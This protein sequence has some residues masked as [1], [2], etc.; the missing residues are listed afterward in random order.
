M[1]ISAAH[2]YSQ[3]T[4]KLYEVFTDANFYQEKFSGVGAKNVQILDASDADE[5]FSITTQRDVPADV[6][7][8]LKKFLGEWNTIKQ[9]EVWQSYGDNEF[10]S[11]ISIEAA[12]VPVKIGGS[13]LLRP[14][15]D[16]CVN[17][18]E[19]EIEC[20]VPFVGKSLAEFVAADSK[21][22]LEQEY[23]FIVSYLRGE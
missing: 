10:G 6:P 14:E 19:L 23:Q 17:D 9:T 7:G 11:E 2:K 1:I 20:S 16:G 5:K 18:I 15:G 13:M 22:S 21:K 4:N 12:G 8:L 3:D